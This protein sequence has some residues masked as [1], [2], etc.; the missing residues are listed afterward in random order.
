[1]ISLA[2]RNGQKSDADLGRLG[3]LIKMWLTTNADFD[4]SHHLTRNT[5][6]RSSV[7]SPQR[8]IACKF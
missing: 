1:G 5:V 7:V 8:V 6:Y 3:G 4:L 2:N